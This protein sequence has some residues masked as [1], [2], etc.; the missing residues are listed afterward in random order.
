M[1]LVKTARELLQTMLNIEH[2]LRPAA[3]NCLGHAF[4]TKRREKIS[5]FTYDVAVNVMDIARR[6]DQPIKDFDKED[7]ERLLN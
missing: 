2:S 1:H 6:Y 3:E 4:F 7:W 5:K